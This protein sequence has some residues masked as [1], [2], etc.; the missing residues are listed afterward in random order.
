MGTSTAVRAVARFVDRGVYLRSNLNADDEARS[1][2]KRY[3]DS[4]DPTRN[5]A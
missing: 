4:P 3:K 1:M 5:T 2:M